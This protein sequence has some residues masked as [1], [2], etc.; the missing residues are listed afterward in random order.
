VVYAWSSRVDRDARA[1][2]Q[3]IALASATLLLAA[4]SYG[5]RQLYVA[6]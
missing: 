5:I 3:A 4:A 6:G 1:K 2:F